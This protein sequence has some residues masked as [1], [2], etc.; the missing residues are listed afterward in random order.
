MADEETPDSATEDEAAVAEPPVEEAPVAAEVPEAEA[1]AGAPEPAEPEL[2][3]ADIAGWAG[4]KLDEMGGST[5]GKVEGVYVDDHSGR[6]EWLLA[7]MGRFGAHCLVPARDAVGGA[8]HVW[9][10]YS[11][12]KIRKAPKVEANSPIQ[13]DREQEMLAHY[14]IG[15]SDV[16]RGAELA[17]LTAE[18]ITARPA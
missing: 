1:A 5:V 9:V 2:T 7:R 3:A 6:P 10:P 11:R 8:G 16:G 13:R 15:S 14:G 4:F 17:K 12:D 18:A